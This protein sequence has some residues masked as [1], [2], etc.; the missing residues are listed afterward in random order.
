MTRIIPHPV[1]SLAL[2]L[3][4]LVLTRFSLGYL[5]LGT[6]LA[7]V[8]GRAYSALQPDRLRIGRW[9]AIP[10]LVLILFGD[11]VRSNIAVTRLLLT[12][13]RSGRRSAFVQVPLRVGSASG[14]GVLAI[15]L[16]ATPGT[17]WVDHDAERG[18]LT[19]HVFDASEADHYRDVIGKTYEPLLLEIFG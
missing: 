2:I 10:R 5:I 4:W 15:I 11:I 12:E 13:G 17:A 9:R 8:A 19:L 16:T 7:L 1:L 14:L 18:I 3:L 6:A